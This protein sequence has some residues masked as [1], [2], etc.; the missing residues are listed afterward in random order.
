VKH[1]PSRK[2]YDISSLI[3]PDDSGKSSPHERRCDITSAGRPPLY[4]YKKAEIEKA[5]HL[6]FQREKT[7][8]S[9]SQMGY[10]HRSMPMPSSLHQHHHFHHHYYR[11]QLMLAADSMNRKSFSERLSP[12]PPPL[13]LSLSTTSSLSRLLPSTSADHRGEESDRHYG[14]R[15]GSQ[16]NHPTLVQQYAKSRH[17]L[18]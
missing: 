14:T 7:L 2:S 15:G 8:L 4:T 13:A 16:T 10:H 6:Q 1:E 17:G 18:T 5:A 11:H 9:N 3:N 12:P